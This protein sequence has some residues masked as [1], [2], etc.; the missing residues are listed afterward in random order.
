MKKIKANRKII[1]GILI[2]IIISGVG[3]Y[4]IAATLI[5]SQDVVY[6]SKTSGLGANNVQNAI[7]KT[8]SNIDTRLSEIEDNLYTIKSF[9]NLVVIPGTVNYA[10]TG[11]SID[12]PA[13]SYCSITATAICNSAC[14]RGIV[15]HN[16]VGDYNSENYAGIEVSS[17]ST[18]LS[19]TYTSHYNENAIDLHIYTKFFNAG[20]ANALSYRGFCATKYK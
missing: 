14:P 7:D 11:V 13:N 8:C 4:A 12:V 1:I 2:G 20:G 16:G 6:D 10:Y 5:N 3:F 19:L 18:R 9:D 17:C 15:M